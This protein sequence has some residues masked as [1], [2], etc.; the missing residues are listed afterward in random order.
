MEPIASVNH[1][2]Q[3]ALQAAQEEIARLRQELSD[4]AR[5]INCAGPVAHRIRILRQE[6]QADLERLGNR[7]AIAEEQRS[8]SEQRAQDA[9][10]ELN[11]PGN[12]LGDE[13]ACTCG[14]WWRVRLE[15]EAQ[16]AQGLEARVADA[17]KALKAVGFTYRE[18]SDTPWFPTNALKLELYEAAREIKINCAGPI[19]HRIRIMRKEH[20]QQNAALRAEVEGRW[21]PIETAP[22]ES[23]QHILVS[24]KHCVDMAFWAT[25]DGLMERAGWYR[26]TTAERIKP[27]HW[28]PLPPPPSERVEG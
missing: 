24:T 18:G 1:A 23:G 12:I 6:Y 8:L 3:Q 5:E 10:K 15:A 19:A 17:E 22:K 28:Q 4:A 20:E 13:E 26:A 2:H 9:V 27:T 14:L 25:G 16:R 21:Q 7:C 11:C